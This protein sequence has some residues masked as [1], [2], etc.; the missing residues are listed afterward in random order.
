MDITQL[1]GNV[2]YTPNLAMKHYMQHCGF[3]G[4]AARIGDYRQ[5]VLY[6]IVK[7]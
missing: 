7:L 1:I 5:R 3:L 4:D 2:V 6:Q